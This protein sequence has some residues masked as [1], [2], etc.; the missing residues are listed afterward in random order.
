MARKHT[1][2][3]QVT[4]TVH[5][6]EDAR[7]FDVRSLLEDLTWVGGCRDPE[8][9]PGFYSLTPSKINILRLKSLDKKGT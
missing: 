9:D 1:R 4:M 3:Y 2:A 7:I 5:V 6:N 8:T